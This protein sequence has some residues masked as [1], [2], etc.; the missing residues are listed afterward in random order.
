MHQLHSIRSALHQSKSF[1]V[2]QL[3]LHL[4]H[5]D[6]IRKW[7]RWHVAL[8]NRQGQERYLA[9]NKLTIPLIAQCCRGI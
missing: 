1:S 9:K 4:S 3:L 5:F 6:H 2:R 7:L 8:G